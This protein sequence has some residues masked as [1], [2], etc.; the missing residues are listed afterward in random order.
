M[1]TC[2]HFTYGQ[3]NRAEVVKLS[4][5]GITDN[6]LSSKYAKESKAQHL[7][8]HLCQVDGIN[9]DADNRL[10]IEKLLIPSSLVDFLE[11]FPL[12]MV[13]RLSPCL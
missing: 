3:T 10:S 13:M 4:S 12:F 1:E 8:D 5:C 7:A 11:L 2:V 9:H 6:A